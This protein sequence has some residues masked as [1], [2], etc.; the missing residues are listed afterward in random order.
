VVRRRTR[1]ISIPLQGTAAHPQV[2]NLRK[3]GTGLMTG[4]RNV[5]C[6]AMWYSLVSCMAGGL[7]IVIL[8]VDVST[9]HY[10]R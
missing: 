4:S 2:R 7:M 10:S 3:Q 6:V 9:I 1:L 5:G 8:V